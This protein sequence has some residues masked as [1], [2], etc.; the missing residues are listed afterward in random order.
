MSGAGRYTDIVLDEKER[1][2]RREEQPVEYLERDV[3]LGR[4]SPEYAGWVAVAG[5]IVLIFSPMLGL[6]V[7]VGVVVLGTALWWGELDRWGRRAGKIVIALGALLLATASVIL[8]LVPASG[9]RCGPPSGVCPDR[10][11]FARSL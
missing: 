3:L 11:G 10:P 8:Y 7:G 2:A 1:P 9:L 5:F 6:F 4:V